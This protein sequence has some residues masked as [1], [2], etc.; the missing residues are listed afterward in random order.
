MTIHECPICGGK[1][2]FKRD[3]QERV[4]CRY[5]PLPV[6]STDTSRT[7]LLFEELPE[8]R[9][10]ELCAGTGKVEIRPITKE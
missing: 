6:G 10:C 5:Y 2:R 8:W 7:G 4:V 3:A 9:T 1:G